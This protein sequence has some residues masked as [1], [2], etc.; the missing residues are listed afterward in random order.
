MSE[1]ILD[2]RNISKSFGE[3]KAL[4]NVDFYLKKGIIHGLLGENGAGKTSLMNII[5]GLYQPDSGTINIY[6][7]KI[8]T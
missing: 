8:N 4:N 5:S 6:N 1:N 7:R 3:T 2:L